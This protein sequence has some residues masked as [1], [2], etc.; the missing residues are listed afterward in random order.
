GRRRVRRV[1]AGGERDELRGRGRPGERDDEGGGRR[2]AVREEREHVPGGVRAEPV[3]ARERPEEKRR[4][5]EPRR[6]HRGTCPWAFRAH[7]RQPEPG[8]ER[9]QEED[10]RERVGCDDEERDDPEREERARMPRE[11][12]LGAD[13]PTREQA[14]ARDEPADEG[15]DGEAEERRGRPVH[16]CEGR[17]APGGAAAPGAGEAEEAEEDAAPEPEREPAPVA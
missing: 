6:E 4:P 14:V 13:R 15:E 2:V 7:L 9:R 16:G 11:H 5:G 12:L 1:A 17:R 10:E 8:V 3:A